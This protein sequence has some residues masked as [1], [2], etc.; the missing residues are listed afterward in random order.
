MKKFY[1][2]LNLKELRETCEL[3]FAHYTYP[4]GM[5]PC[6]TCFLD[7]PQRYW[8][9]ERRPQKMTLSDGTIV[10]ELNGKRV[11]VDDFAYLLFFNSDR[12]GGYASKGTRIESVNVA[13]HFVSDQQK[14][15]VCRLLSEQLGKDYVVA[16]PKFR[17][18]VLRIYTLDD[19]RHRPKEKDYYY[20]SFWNNGEYDFAGELPAR[21]E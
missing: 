10:Y 5:C 16:E 7:F 18:T 3:D 14:A 9:P 1:H 4:H 12:D 21:V 6:C 15:D 19:F 2:E 17:W 20:N 8:K 13:Y 11:S